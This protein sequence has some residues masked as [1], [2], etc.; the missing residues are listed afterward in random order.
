MSVK[1]STF[2]GVRLSGKEAEKFTRQVKYGRP[3]KAAVESARRGK[4]M[5]SEFERTG[6][7]IVHARK[8]K[9]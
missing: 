4:A 3:K 6:Q 8:T 7:V 2:G 9:S 5:L 1:T